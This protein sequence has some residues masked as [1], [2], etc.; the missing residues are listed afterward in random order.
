[1]NKKHPISELAPERLLVAPSVLASDF[2][3]LGEELVRV[4]KAGCDLIHL[5]VMD[6]HFVPNIT[7]GPALVAAIRKLSNLTFDAH[8]MI[9]HPL[10]YAE[11]FSK[12]GADHISFHIE[13]D[14]KPQ[15][16]IDAIKKAGCSVGVTLKPKTPAETI[17]PYI[18][19]LDM[20]LIMTVEPGFGGQSFMHDMVPKIK[21]VHEIVAKSGRRIHIQVDG[22]IDSDTV[23]IVASAG[24]NVMVAG[25]SV[26]RNPAG[27]QQAIEKLHAAQKQLLASRK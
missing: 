21:T 10:Q 1:M 22:G 14:D 3:K 2:A 20:V 16:V 12:A 9:S 26:F 19:Q 24:A 5:D 25:T 18:D 6:G 13:S 15:E 4:E 17:L 27:A 7:F 11:A 23:G 8:L